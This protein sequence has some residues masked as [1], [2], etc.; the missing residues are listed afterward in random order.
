MPQKRVSGTIMHV[1]L[2]TIADVL[3]PTLELQLGNPWIF[4]NL[5]N[6]K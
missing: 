5:V 2:N 1:A 4:S 6:T 3:D